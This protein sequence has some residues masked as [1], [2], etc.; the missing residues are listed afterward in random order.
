[1]AFPDPSSDLEVWQVS[2]TLPAYAPLYSAPA[3][4]EVNL[5]LV[6]FGRGTE[7]GDPVFVS[8]D[9]HLGGWL[10]GG[11]DGLQRWGTNVIGSIVDDADFGPLL[12]A[13]FD[14]NAGPNEAHLSSGDSGGGVFVFNS[15]TNQ[16]ELAGIN[17]G[18][19]G[20]FSSSMNGANAFNGAMFDTAGLFVQDGPNWVAAP[21]PSA[22]YS[23]EIAAHR[24][25]I[26]SMV[27]QLTS[28]VSRKTHGNAGAF[29][30]TLPSSGSPAI[31]GRSGGATND[32]MLVYTFANNVSVQSAA[33]TSGTG[34]VTNFTVVGNTVT[35]NLTGVTNAQ[36]ITVALG[37]VNNGTTTSD[38]EAAMSI[39]VADTNADTF[40]DAADVS[41]TKS[42]SGNP[43]NVS[44]FREDVNADGFIDAVDV[45]LV[46]S[47]SGTALLTSGVKSTPPQSG[48]KPLPIQ[49]AK[50]GRTQLLKPNR[51]RANQ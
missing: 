37:S 28:V 5:N 2:G 8:K 11:G 49:S 43:V 1:A 31:E 14:N 45:S 18:V 17:L 25:F 16:W 21:N 33:L 38:V 7:R 30:L 29:N 36:T 41:Q 3:G 4:T 42:Q 20:P 46:K 50:I 22:F 6:V 13:P 32:Y 35:V 48:I 39:L 51:V 44:N 19:D 9:A 47:K 15:T 34:S 24:R 10:W 12:R 26:E 40:V 27:M 23:T